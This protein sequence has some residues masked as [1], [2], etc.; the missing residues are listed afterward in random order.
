MVKLNELTSHVYIPIN[1]DVI[2]ERELEFAASSMK[3]RGGGLFPTSFKH[4][5]SLYTCSVV[6]PREYVVFVCETGNVSFTCNPQDR[7]FVI[8]KQLQGNTN[9]TTACFVI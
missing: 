2:T 9:A 8:T 6:A 3:E 4:V 7:K 1:D 5:N